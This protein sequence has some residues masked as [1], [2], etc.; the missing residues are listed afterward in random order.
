MQLNLIIMEERYKIMHSRR[1]FL[2]WDMRF[3]L[4]PYIILKNHFAYME[5]LGV[6]YTVNMVLIFALVK[7][8]YN[9]LKLK[10]TRKKEMIIFCNSDQKKFIRILVGSRKIILEIW[11]R[12]M[13]FL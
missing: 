11:I 1:C 5:K 4:L 10:N 12:N 7:K 3:R 13:I 9:V 6:N 2:I 8:A